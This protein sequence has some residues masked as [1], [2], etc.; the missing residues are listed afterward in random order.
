MDSPYTS[1]GYTDASLPAKAVMVVSV[2]LMALGIF[3]Q[4]NAGFV[5]DDAYM[6]LRYADNFL[7][8]GSLSWNPGGR[9]TYGLTSLLFLTVVLP[10]RVVVKHNASL[11]GSLSSIISGLLFV[12]FLIGLLLRLARSERVNPILLVLFGL[13][14]LANAIPNLASHF[15]SG[16]DTMFALAFLTG[17]IFLARGPERG[18]GYRSCIW[19]GI[20][21]G[22]AFLARPDLLVFTLAVPFL[23]WLLGRTTQER[24]WAAVTALVSLIALIAQIVSTWNYF[25]VPL[26]LSFYAKGLNSYGP[27]LVSQY[28]LIPFTEF[29]R[30]FVSYWYLYLLIAADLLINFS[31]WRS[32]STSLEK[33]LLIASCVFTLY[34]MLFVLQIMYRPQRFYYPTLP[35]LIYLAARGGIRLARCIP[36]KVRDA[37]VLTPGW[38]P[39]LVCL[40]ITGTLLGPIL[41]VT[42]TIAKQNSKGNLLSFDLKENYRSRFSDFWVGLEDVSKLPDDL[43]IATS[44]VGRVAAMNTRKQIVDLAGLNELSFATSGFSAGYLLE[45]LRPDLIYLPHPHYMERIAEIVSYDRFEETFDHYPAS[46]LG[47]I[48]GMAIRRDSKYYGELIE[49]IKKNLPQYER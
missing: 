24:K 6:F 9:P 17:Y 35:A 16:M 37:T 5:L 45:S 46:R 47:S 20:W 22:L 4:F 31:Y 8:E 10:V 48:M 38:L 42:R 29:I 7:R 26:P 25:G 1:Y 43:V 12:S 23:G 11:A 32:D 3:S 15:V 41:T 40:L 21:G 36:G 27:F 28:R 19:M 34:Y 30:F 49:I 14:P 2:A 33:G 44:E 13:F 39:W 18:W